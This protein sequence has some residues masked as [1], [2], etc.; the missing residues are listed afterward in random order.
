MK[1]KIKLDGPTN[2]NVNFQNAGF[3]SQLTEGLKNELLKIVAQELVP[4]IKHDNAGNHKMG[5]GTL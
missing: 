1:F 5:G 2:V 3:L 4:Q